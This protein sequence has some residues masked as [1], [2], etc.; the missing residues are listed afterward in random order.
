MNESKYVALML[1]IAALWGG[2]FPLVKWL[3]GYFGPFE[4]IAMRSVLGVIA[5]FAYMKFKGEKISPGEWKAGA[6]LGVLLFVGLSAQTIGLN[7]TTATNSAFVTGI[8]V[9]LTPLFA[10]FFTGKKPGIRTYGAAVLAF[11][12][13]YL[14][15]GF[16]SNGLE[17]HAAGIGNAGLIF[18]FAFNFGDAITLVT[19]FCFAIHMCFLGKIAKGMDPVRIT[20]VQSVVG[21][22]LGIG[23]ALPLE[24]VPAA[25][26]LLPLLSIAFL[27]IIVG[28]TSLVAQAY[29]QRF[30]SAPK[31]AII[32]LMEPV[33]AAILGAIFLSEVLGTVQAVGAVLIL[34]GMASAES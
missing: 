19:A 20:L 8:L 22:V 29:A 15:S 7:Y 28:A 18:G 16:G 31:I 6:I 25:F 17:G 11:I 3:L 33:F 27:G 13:L 10:P 24:G 2:T 1:A 5:L 4:I 9:I 12:G 14:L 23:V 30:I 34:I 26:P 32:F 21:A